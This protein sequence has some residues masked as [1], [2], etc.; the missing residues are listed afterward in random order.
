ML[1]SGCINISDAEVVTA[2]I[3]ESTIAIASALAKF[4]KDAPALITE[5]V[6]EVNSSVFIIPLHNVKFPVVEPAPVLLP[7]FE[8]LQKRSS[9]NAWIF[10][11]FSSV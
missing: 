2:A 1:R 5:E 10:I 9:I 7:D 11:V 3:T 8:P 4:E 6:A